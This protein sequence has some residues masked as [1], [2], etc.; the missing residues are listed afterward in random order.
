MFTGPTGKPLDPRRDLD[1]WKALLRA[2]GVRESRLHDARHTAATLMLVQ[3]VHDRVVMDLMGWSS[4]AMLKRYSHIVD[5]LRNDAAL[6]TG[7]ALYG[8]AP[9]IGSTTG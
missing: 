9:A 8:D 2:A 3:G 1:E 5:A 7:A 4:T 6:R